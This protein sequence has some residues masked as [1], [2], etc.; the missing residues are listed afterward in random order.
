MCACCRHVDIGNQP[1]QPSESTANYHDI[2]HSSNLQHLRF[3]LVHFMC[4]N[5]RLGRQRYDLHVTV[6]VCYLSTLHIVL[7]WWIYRFE[8]S[9]VNWRVC[10]DLLFHQVDSPIHFKSNVLALLGSPGHWLDALVIMLGQLFE[11]W[12]AILSVG[13]LRDD[14]K[15]QIARRT[16]RVSGKLAMTI[17]TRLTSCQHTRSCNTFPTSYFLGKFTPVCLFDHFKLLVCTTG[18]VG[19]TSGWDGRTAGVLNT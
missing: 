3:E 5:N 19:C 18:L 8:K 16:H 12:V 11:C 15:N 9:T 4:R 1:N 6:D 14:F 17:L 10:N 7:T 2:V 13:M